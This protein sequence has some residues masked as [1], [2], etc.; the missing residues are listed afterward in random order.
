MCR[1][2]QP[3]SST[4]N[5]PPRPF[6]IWIAQS[7]LEDLAGILARQVGLDHDMLGD[8]VVGECGLELRAETA[9]VELHTGLRFHHGHQRLAELFVGN[10]EYRAIVHTRQSMEREFKRFPVLAERQAQLAGTLSGGEQQMLAISRGLMSRPKMLLMDE[11]SV[12]FSG[13]L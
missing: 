10:A 2:P 11:P 5:P 4:S 13:L 12:R 1:C 3:I 6:P 9:N 8:L 7:A